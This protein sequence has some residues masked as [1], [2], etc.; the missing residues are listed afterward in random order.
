[1]KSNSDFRRNLESIQNEL[2][3]FFCQLIPNRNRNDIKTNKIRCASCL[4][5]R[6]KACKK[7]WN[8]K[9]CKENYEKNNWLGRL[10]P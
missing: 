7:K 5:Y 3:R 1:M 6:S 8:D 10:T 9:A 2:F 4:K